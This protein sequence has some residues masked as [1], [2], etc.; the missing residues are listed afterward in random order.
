MKES[1][2][3]GIRVLTKRCKCMVTAML[4][5]IMTLTFMQ[6]KPVKAVAAEEYPLYLCGTKVTGE[7]A[8]DIMGD[9]NF[10]Y[11]NE[12][13]TLTIRGDLECKTKMPTV[14]LLNDGIEDLTIYVE[15]DS[16]LTQ[17]FVNPVVSIMKNTTITGPGVLNVE[18]GIRTISV[19]SCK[20][21]VR[22]AT[23]N[24]LNTNTDHNAAAIGGTD[25]SMAECSLEIVD[26]HVTARNEKNKQLSA[27]TG[28]NKE[29]KFEGCEPIVP[30]ASERTVLKTAKGSI[31]DAGKNN[32]QDVLIER[33]Y[34]LQIV[35]QRVYDSNKDDILGNGVFSYDEKTKTLTIKGN[36]QTDSSF[37]VI[38][39]DINGLTVTTAADSI[40]SCVNAWFIYNHG[41]ITLTTNGKLSVL[42]GEVGIGSWGDVD[43]KDADLVIDA[44]SGAIEGFSY[45]KV[46]NII[47]SDVNADSKNQEAVR[48][49]RWIEIKNCKIV[50]PED[51]VVVHYERTAGIG[52]PQGNFVSNVV[53]KKSQEQV[54]TTTTTTTAT[55]TT[56][57]TT[58]CTV[59][60]T[61][62]MP[63][64]EGV[65]GDVNCDGKVELADAILIM[66]ALANPDKYG[67][68]GSA[69][70]H[71]TA[72]GKLNGDVDKTTPGLTGGD[73]MKIQEFLLGKRESLE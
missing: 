55:T 20:L 25:V 42:A 13:K 70:K 19:D 3:I 1:R 59:G 66:Q 37:S 33:Y 67:E 39:N 31:V 48:G 54:T 9:G 24:S 71:I 17:P 45:M 50:T 51:G 46:L 30:S 64:V 53:I 4:M 60:P 29:L 21:T 10:S 7:N 32:V 41:D 49:F 2:T 15:K 43:I 63:Y 5:L 58:T 68:N 44:Q 22:D 26:S 11:D 38:Q 40:I 28:F 35:E 12:T 34:D 62:T 8:G 61:T 47:N 65:P 69:P 57:S 72:R 14:L 6:P 73:A 27:V 18:G 16:A 56:T 52:D 23:L 36:Y